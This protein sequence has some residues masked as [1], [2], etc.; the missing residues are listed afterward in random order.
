MR[1]DCVQLLHNPLSPAQAPPWLYLRNSF[2]VLIFLAA[3]TVKSKGF[4]NCPIG[5][6]GWDFALCLNEGLI[7]RHNPLV[8]RLFSYIISINF[9]GLMPVIVRGF[10]W[11]NCTLISQGWSIFRDRCKPL[12]KFVV[13]CSWIFSENRVLHLCLCADGNLRELEGGRQWL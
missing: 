6:N 12:T 7:K 3:S 1:W 5:L 13:T 8:F 4:R 2:G 11:Y 9:E 10:W